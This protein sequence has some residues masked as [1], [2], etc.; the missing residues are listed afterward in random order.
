MGSR[1][2]RRPLVRC[3]SRFEARAWWRTAACASSTA[4]KPRSD[5][6]LEQNNVLLRFE[7]GRLRD[8]A[9]ETGTAFSRPLV[10]RGLAV[11]DFDNDG[12]S[13]LLIS[14]NDGPAQLLE[15]RLPATGDWIG[16]RLLDRSGRRDALGAV[17]TLE[18]ED[19]TKLVRRSYTDG[20]YLSASDARVVF[21]LVNR[22]RPKSLV[23]RWPDGLEERFPTPVAGSYGD[24]REGTGAA[25]APAG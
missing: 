6:T 19:G 12:D 8:I 23:V 2:G 22:P 20:S 3:R 24:L 7:G 21:G 11:A 17:A 5:P 10:N 13:D 18:L 25:A 14:T 1:L 15:N 4:P 9:G 16:I